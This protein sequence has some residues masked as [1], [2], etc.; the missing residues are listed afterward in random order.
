MNG[1]LW[2]LREQAKFLK[3]KSGRLEEEEIGVV[4]AFPEG[5]G[6]MILKVSF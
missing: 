2:K 5:I 3:A 4:M 6:Q 1:K